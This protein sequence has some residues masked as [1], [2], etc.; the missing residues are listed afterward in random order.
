MP[1]IYSA[2]ANS[3]MATNST[4]PQTNPIPDN[5]KALPANHNPLAAFATFPPN[6][7]FATQQPGETIIL[8]LRQHPIV[9]VPWILATIVLL[10]APNVVNFV[11][12]ISFLP[13]RFQS[14]VII[15]WYLLVMAFVVERFL[16]WYFNVYI[17]T[18]ERIIDVDFYSLIYQN[19]SIAR[20]DKVED[21]T[22]VQGG[23][24]AAFI[25]YGDVQIQTAAEKNEFEFAK[26]PQPGKVVE[27]ISQLSEID[28][29]N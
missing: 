3:P 23:A 27:I 1:E 29:H 10:L 17:V 9:N 14:M 6:L 16:N 20:L 19:L 24:L 5:I 4:F 28:E 8:L 22:F 26:V 11:P 12:L 18:N 25:D 13:F 2:Q 21:V 7:G 15:L